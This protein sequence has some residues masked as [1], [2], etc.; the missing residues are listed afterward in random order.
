VALY[1]R[2]QTFFRDRRPPTLIV[3][4]RYDPFFTMAGA[5]AYQRDLPD[6]ELHVL[7]AGH[8]ALETHCLEVTALIRNSLK[9]RL[10]AGGGR[11]THPRPGREGEK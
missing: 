1:P 11:L 3:W 7:D 5:R 2:F 6:A 4:G 10:G 8:F 9:R